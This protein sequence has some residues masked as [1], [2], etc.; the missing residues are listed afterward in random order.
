MPK[1][2]EV[3][4]TVQ[5]EYTTT[6]FRIENEQQ[7]KDAVMEDLELATGDGNFFKNDVTFT[8][9]TE[10]EYVSPYESGAK[11]AEDE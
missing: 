10:V 11:K 8:S 2:Y 4:Y 6:V 9:I 1:H 5:G 3:A 7:A